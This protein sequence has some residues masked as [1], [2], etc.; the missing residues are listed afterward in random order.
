MHVRRVRKNEEKE[1][2]RLKALRIRS[3]RHLCNQLHVEK[4][5]LELILK[6]LSRFYRER[7]ETKKGKV[8]QLS[9]PQ[10]KLKAIL[11]R[12]NA[13]LQRLEFPYYVHGGL[14]G[15]SCRTNA[16]N[17][18][19]KP[20]LLKAD[21][22]DFFPSIKEARV[23]RMFEFR[24]QC[25]S[26]VACILATLTTYKD[27][28]PQGSPTSTI[29][30]TLV[31][32]HLAYRLAKLAED[33]GAA[34]SQ[35][36]DDMIISGPEHIQKLEGLVQRIIEDEDFVCHPEK[37]GS[38]SRSNEQVVT[39]LRVNYGIDAPRLKIS[40]IR[41]LIVNINQRSRSSNAEPVISAE[42]DSLRGKISWIGQCNPG[43]G[44]QLCKELG[45]AMA[46]NHN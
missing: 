14:K 1:P 31:T 4:G 5:E 2:M 8:R 15:K 12:L 43:I 9:I 28:V 37:L 21:I 33:H 11:R 45:S 24:L 29:V 10:G 27:R 23:R 17:H 3:V 36:V 20:L 19:N 26:K 25:S 6:N 22:K 35:Y 40:E 39:G 32:E 41:A 46:C 18:T 38:A 44:R 13:K 16:S 30:S 34:F 7:P 42:F